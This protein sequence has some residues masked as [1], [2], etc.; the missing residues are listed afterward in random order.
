MFSSTIFLMF[1]QI[2]LLIA[3]T[4][5][6]ALELYKTYE[7]LSTIYNIYLYILSIY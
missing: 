5:M 4:T 1:A 7:A 2:L 6:Q 3:T